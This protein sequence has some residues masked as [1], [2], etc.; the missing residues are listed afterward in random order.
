MLENYFI[1]E[2][3]ANWAATIGLAVFSIIVAFFHSVIIAALYSKKERLSFKKGYFAIYPSVV[4]LTK[5]IYPKYVFT[6]GA[7]IFVSLFLVSILVLLIGMI[8]ETYK[9]A[10][11]ESITKT[12]SSVLFL[13]VKHIYITALLILGLIFFSTYFFIFIFIYIGIQGFIKFNSKNSFTNIQA[14]LPTS[15]IASMAMGLVEIVGEVNM[16]EPLLTRIGKKEC[17][18]YRYKIEEKQTNSE[19]KDSYSIITSIRKSK[20]KKA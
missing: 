17:I 10:K 13:F 1:F 12:N 5:I 4:I 2:T 7:I 11:K 8:T 3:Q 9:Y 15:N 19:G 6:I 14:N 16:Q 18:G 20:F